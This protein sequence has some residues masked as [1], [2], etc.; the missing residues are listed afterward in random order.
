MISATALRSPSTDTML[1]IDKAAALVAQ[2]CNRD[3]QGHGDTTVIPLA[4]LFWSS[5][6]GRAVDSGLCF[7][8]LLLP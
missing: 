7:H 1:V 4:L 2:S 3:S 6:M 5:N 8:P